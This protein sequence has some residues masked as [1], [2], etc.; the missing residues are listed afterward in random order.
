LQ[1]SLICDKIK[2]EIKKGVVMFYIRIA[3]IDICIKNKYEFVFLQ[4]KGYLTD[5]KDAELTVEISDEMIAE[6]MALAEEEIS[7]GYAES[8]CVYREICEQLPTKFDAFFLHSA[9]I[10]YEGK[11]YAFS[12][13]SGTGK[14]T[15]IRL[16]RRHFG[17][18]VHVING[19]KP[20][21]RNIDGAM[22]AYGTPWCGKEGWQNNTRVK[23]FALCFLERAEKNSIRSLDAGEAVMRIF[24]Q[25]LTPEDM[26]TV[27][28]LFPLLD[29][30]LREVP[31]YVLSC[32][33]TTEAA[34]VAY[35]GMNLN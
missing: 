10:E 27:D 8:I 5:T 12:A 28:A 34:D 19:D 24:H 35:R 16:W 11:G 13:K 31:C 22:H 25:I 15:H 17:E 29:K 4:C 18:G 2:G 21:I 30:M 6:E 32:D 26:Q 20:I 1:I 9:V 33:P 23:L 3:D 14:S 7:H